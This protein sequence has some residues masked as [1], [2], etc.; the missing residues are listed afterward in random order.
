M[1]RR[2]NGRS[3]AW[4][5]VGLPS[6][7]YWQVNVVPRLDGLALCRMPVLVTAAFQYVTIF[8]VTPRTNFKM[9]GLVTAAFQ[10]V[11]FFGVTPR[12]NLKMPVLVT[13][14]FQY[15]A[16]FGVTPRT[17]FKM[18]GFVIAVFQRAMLFGVST[19][20]QLQDTWLCHCGFSACRSVF[21][22]SPPPPFRVLPVL[23]VANAGSCVG[24]RLK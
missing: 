13:V 17:N 1:H 3:S 12:T 9:P 18:P 21:P 10:Y 2:Q 11:T 23:A 19:S 20:H 6:Q 24:R 16:F 15:V 5:L 7:P 4:V 8:G 14:A 22:S